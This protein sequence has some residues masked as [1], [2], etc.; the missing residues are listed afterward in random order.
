[1][2]HMLQIADDF[3]KL[4]DS[5]SKYKKWCKELIKQNMEFRI[6]GICKHYDDRAYFCEKASVE[7]YENNEYYSFVDN[8]NCKNWEFFKNV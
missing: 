4:T 6:C 3:K 7:E 1:M 2:A 8:K 5:E